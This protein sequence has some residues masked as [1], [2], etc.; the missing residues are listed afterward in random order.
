MSALYGKICYKWLSYSKEIK[1]KK[2]ETSTA[3][4]IREMSTAMATAT[5]SY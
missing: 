2:M 5:V 4:G 1:A 3:M